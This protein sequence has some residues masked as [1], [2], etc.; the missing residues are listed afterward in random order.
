MNCRTSRLSLCRWISHIHKCRISNRFSM[1]ELAH[2]PR[3]AFGKAAAF[4]RFAKKIARVRNS[5]SFSFLRSA[6]LVKVPQKPSYQ[7]PRAEI[8]SRRFCTL[9]ERLT[10]TQN[11][12]AFCPSTRRSPRLSL[13]Q[14]PFPHCQTPHPEKVRFLRYAQGG[15]G[16]RRCRRPTKKRRGSSLRHFSCILFSSRVFQRLC[17]DLQN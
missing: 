16:L 14:Q 13:S 9:C 8:R 11:A 10:E 5:E 7:K 2:A 17:G 12:T 3:F 1:D 4:R 6:A 15:S